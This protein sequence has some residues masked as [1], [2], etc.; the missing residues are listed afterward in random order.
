MLLH[1][2]VVD[3]DTQAESH[4]QRNLMSFLIYDEKVEE[5]VQ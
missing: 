1:G 3:A 2:Y 4:P 5:R